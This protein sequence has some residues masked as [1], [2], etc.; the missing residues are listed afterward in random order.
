MRST[1]DIEHTILG[2]LFKKNSLLASIDLA[3]D[4]FS[5]Q[6][7]REIFKSMQRVVS[8]NEPID[9]ITI[10]EDLQKILG[11]DYF[12][13]VGDIVA[14]SYATD[15][16]HHVKALKKQA[17]VRSVSS[18]AD[19][20]SLEIHIGD[21]DLVNNAIRE[22]MALEGSGQKKYGFTFQETG[23]LALDAIERNYE[24]EGLSGLTTGLIE[25]DNA[26]GGLHDS[27]LI[28]VGARPAMGKTAMMLNLAN[29]ANCPVGIF[30]TEQPAEQIGLRL[31]SLDGKIS[32]EAIRAGKFLTDDFIKLKNAITTLKKMKGEVYEKSSITISELMSQARRMKFDYDIGALYVDYIQRIKSGE[33]L[34]RVD[35]IRVVCEGLKEIAK[36]LNIP[37]IA[38]AQINREVEKRTD[39]RPGMADLKESGAIEQEA[40]MVITLYRDEVYNEDSPQKGTAELIICKNR[41]G[42]TGICYAAWRGQFLEFANLE[43]NYT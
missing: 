21:T 23:H 41:H 14:N 35:E 18:I 19:R 36:E 26:T 43:Q 32:L 37:V 10:M 25:L 3:A 15:I 1:N 5:N 31:C 13:V 34:S 16:T 22:L 4:N 8:R 40:D 28:V 30:S 42:R 20:L 27:D 33:K 12:S 7:Y 24:N 6:P 9:P 39:K 29:S 38:L 17:Y 11:K 2:G